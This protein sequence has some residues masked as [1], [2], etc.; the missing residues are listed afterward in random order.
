MGRW[1]ACLRIQKVNW[2]S[3]NAGSAVKKYLGSE[4]KRVGL[5]AAADPACWFKL[6]PKF[7]LQ[8]ANQCA[9]ERVDLHRQKF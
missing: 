4:A 3:L 5:K 9:S 7:H 1:V 2:K 8:M 6:P